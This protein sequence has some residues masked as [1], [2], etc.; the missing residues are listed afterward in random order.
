MK[1]AQIVL[2][3]PVELTEEFERDAERNGFTRTGFVAYLYAMWR[4]GSIGSRKSKQPRKKDGRPRL[5]TVK[6]VQDARE[7]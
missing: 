6:D 7:S 3:W 2:N 5:K 4:S 1:R